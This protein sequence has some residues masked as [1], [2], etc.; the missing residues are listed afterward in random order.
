MEIDDTD[1]RK[2]QY[3]ELRCFANSNQL[4]NS[5]KNA[6]YAQQG[7][8]RAKRLTLSV[9]SILSQSVITTNERTKP[10]WF[11]SRPTLCHVPF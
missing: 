2:Q 11:R 1:K 7:L 3:I 9:R 8:L 6:Q 10:S 4:I 5:Q